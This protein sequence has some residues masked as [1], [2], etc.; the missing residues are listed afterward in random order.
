M[1]LRHDIYDCRMVM[2]REGSSA[3]DRSTAGLSVFLPKNRLCSTVGATYCTPR[4]DVN[5]HNREMSLRPRYISILAA[6][7]YRHT[8]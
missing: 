4:L 2:T 6:A 8:V 7:R 3:P 1:K 5:S